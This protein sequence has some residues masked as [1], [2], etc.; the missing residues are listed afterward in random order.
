[1]RVLRLHGP[2]DLRMHDEP[3]PEPAPGEVRLRIASV[4]ICASDLHY[5]RDGR[6][7]S[8]VIT[9][10]LVLGHEA[11]AVVDALGDGV[12]GL[13]LG[14]RVA[15]EPTKPCGRC[16]YCR[17]RRF[18]VCPNVEFFGTPP[19]D[20]CLRDY[21]CWPAELAIKIPDKLTFDEAA[22]VEPLAIGVH[23]V[24][25][26]EAKPTDTVAVLG[27]GAIGLSVLQTAKVT[28]AKRV[29]VSEPV[30]ERRE[31]A[32]KLGASD[33]ID[34]SQPIVDFAR[35]TDGRGADI[36]IECT[37]E[38]GPVRESCRIA[39]VLGRV[40]IIGIPD[41]DDYSF[42]ASPSRR[43]ELTVIFCRRSNLAAK[44]AIQWVAEG[45]IDA[46]C[47]ATHRFPLEQAEE[48]ISLAIAKSDGVIRAVVMVNS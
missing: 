43:R 46:A 7:G 47:M 27:A 36:V 29:I 5:Y 10:P 37:G 9:T 22:M 31:I 16:E 2:R 48:A 6:I 35:L 17:E 4:G 8:T 24:R 23:A 19:I 34:A 38:D 33:V 42:E 12:T 21:L 18:N 3:I 41:S 40:V 28:G 32:R 11:S 13:Q 15:I 14:D 1:M 30:P 26:A 45:K 44:T 39:R 25:L 20:G